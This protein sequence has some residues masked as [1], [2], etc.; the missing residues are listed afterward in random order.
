LK[1]KEAQRAPQNPYQDANF[2]GSGPNPFI[3]PGKV[4]DLPISIGD[5]DTDEKEY[6]AVP[7]TGASDNIINYQVCMGLVI[8]C[9]D[10]ETKEKTFKVADKQ[11]LASI[12]RVRL[13]CSFRKS[14]T[15]QARIVLEDVLFQVCFTLASEITIVLGK[16]FLKEMEI[17]TTASHRLV[18]RFRPPGLVPRVMGLEDVRGPATRLRI[19]MNSALVEAFPDTG[20]EVNLI[21]EAYA[22]AKG[23]PIHALEDDDEKQ[24]KLANNSIV[25]LV[26]KVI[27]KVSI[28]DSHSSEENTALIKPE[29]NIG[30][31]QGLRK[32][33][34]ESSIDTILILDNNSPNISIQSQERT[35]FVLRGLSYDVLLGQPFLHSVDAFNLHRGAFIDTEEHETAGTFNSIY[36][37]KRRKRNCDKTNAPS[38]SPIPAGLGNPTYSLSGTNAELQ[39]AKN[40]RRQKY[41]RTIE[42]VTDADKLKNSTIEL[43]RDIADLESAFA[44]ANNRGAEGSVGVARQMLH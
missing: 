13:R 4:F 12:G 38:K 27:V 43:D 44:M 2:P 14:P 37:M 11:T 33:L 9:E 31:L 32:L 34:K 5:D 8:E 16:Q 28:L 25:N 30:G 23:F 1:D 40:A 35:F 29:R 21:S 22:T 26:G 6:M 7:D 19:F 3:R 10:E 42:G 39:Q 17:L 36:L 41:L 20:S 24:V 15:E 18:E